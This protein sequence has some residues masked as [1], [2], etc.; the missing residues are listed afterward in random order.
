MLV[1]CEK[2]CL[3]VR[4]EA[5]DSDKSYAPLNQKF[6]RAQWYMKQRIILQAYFRKKDFEVLKVIFA[7]C[8]PAKRP[9]IVMLIT[10][11]THSCSYIRR[12]SLPANYFGDC[13]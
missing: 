1:L 6:E 4:E 12:H 2:G 7:F 11:K 5:G 10:K 8:L 13:K 9:S 3:K